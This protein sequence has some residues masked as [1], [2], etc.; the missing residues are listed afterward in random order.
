[1]PSPAAESR[2]LI[3][4]FE[5]APQRYRR[6]FPNGRDDDWLALVPAE[7]GDGF[8][9]WLRERLNMIYTVIAR[10]SLRGGNLIYLG[11]MELAAD[12]APLAR[13]SAAA[14]GERV[15]TV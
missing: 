3:W 1:M 14:T 15:R 5:S 6:C 4:R 12:T 13:M 8:I 10:H 2:V 11:A 7:I 9:E